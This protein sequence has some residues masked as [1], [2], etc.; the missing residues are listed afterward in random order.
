[1]KLLEATER[2][3]RARKVAGPVFRVRLAVGF[4]PLSLQTFI[5]AHLGT[6][7]P[8]RQ[9]V[10]ENG[11]YD[12]LLGTLGREDPGHAVLCVVEWA[13]LDSRLSA[14]ST[15]QH[16]LAALDEIVDHARRRAVAI[17]DALV[18]SGVNSRIACPPTLRLPPLFPSTCQT[19]YQ[20]CRAVGRA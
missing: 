13:D 11:D 10:V 19:P 15:A 4:T 16:S 8:T 18:A 14:R 17:A 2:S 5:E 12:D 7:L 3:T 20:E 6:L 1:M 9:L